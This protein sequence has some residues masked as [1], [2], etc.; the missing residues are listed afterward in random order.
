MT[1]TTADAPS[2][3]GLAARYRPAVFAD[4]VGQRHV[5]AVL[6]RAVADGKVPQ[7]I[8]FS[9]G[10]G[11]G[12]TTIARVLAAA[13]L[14][15]DPKDGDACGQC[16]SCRAVKQGNHLDVVEFDA[17][18]NGQKEQI[19][20]LASRA[21]TSPVMGQRRIYIIDEAHGLS[22]PGGQAFLKLLEEPP[23]HVT[24]LLATTDPDRMLRTNRG[25]CVEF[26]LHQ[27]SDDEIVTHLVDVANR[28]GQH[29][30]RREGEAV[31]AATDPALGVRGALMNLERVLAMMDGG[32]VDEAITVSLGVA[33]AELVAALAASIES[34]SSVRAVVIAQEIR[35]IVGDDGLR[36][37]LLRW[38]RARLK[39]AD[40]DSAAREAG[41]VLGRV[42]E[43]GRGEAG[44]DVVVVELS[45]PQRASGPDGIEAAADRAE[46]A[47]Q[48]LEAVLERWAS[49]SEARAMNARD[50]GEAEEHGEEE[51]GP[52]EA[53]TDVEA[54]FAS[55]A[56][57]SKVAAAMLRSCQWRLDGNRILVEVPAAM[58]ARF[59][60]MAAVIAEATGLEVIVEQS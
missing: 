19:R 9:G 59:S 27:P 45:S 26:A 51:V 32:D 58:A 12:K 5:V 22:G 37:E 3:R 36:R 60:T 20:D 50:V 34:G 47:A 48:R 43:A 30:G 14:C 39:A 25:R 24:F 40:S 44:T 15:Q 17:A 7:Q 28:E 57:V 42:V 16:P 29:L 56:A 1:D 38:A 21:Q 31:W 53:G 55:V 11:L 10:S 8:L 33:P 4:V 52:G 46:A 54:V 2:F 41:W 13:L 49:A 35:Q 23:A 6:K 18:S